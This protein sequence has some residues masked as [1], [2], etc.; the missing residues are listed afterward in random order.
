[1]YQLGYDDVVKNTDKLKRYQGVAFSYD[2]GKNSFNRGSGKLK[3]KSIGF[4]NT[5]LRNKGH[6]LDLAFK[7]YDADRTSQCLIPKARRL[8]VLL[9][10]QVSA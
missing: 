4:Y 9:T 6:Y 1:M 5:D 2:D 10:T 7:I 8:A 3:A